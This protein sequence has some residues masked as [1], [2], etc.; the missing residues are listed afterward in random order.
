MAG[1]ILQSDTKVAWASRTDSPILTRAERIDTTPSAASSD[2]RPPRTIFPLAEHRFA[3]TSPSPFSTS[4]PMLGRNPNSLSPFPASEGTTPLTSDG[5]EDPVDADGMSNPGVSNN[6]D[7]FQ[8]PNRGI[9]SA[10]AE[11]HQLHRKITM[12]TPV[13]KFS[14][15]VI[16]DR[17]ELRNQQSSKMRTHST[18]VRKHAAQFQPTLSVQRAIEEQRGQESHEF[19]LDSTA[20]I[21]ALRHPPASASAGASGQFSSSVMGTIEEQRGQSDTPDSLPHTAKKAEPPEVNDEGQPERVSFPGQAEDAN[22]KRAEESPTWGEPFRLQWVKVER[23]PFY[24]TR[25]LRNPWN[26]DREIKVSRDGTELEPRVGQ[27]LLEEWDRVIETHSTEK[28]SQQ[29]GQGGAG[30]GGR[31][32]GKGKGGGA[33]GGVQRGKK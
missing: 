3:D 26:H 9:V 5:H 31:H 15:D 29:S 16:P 13:A 1:P 4:N 21:R 11:L 17:H 27:A 18:P 28:P 7:D 2:T 14:A 23:L 30:G 12:D 32:Q 8:E 24:R 20:P 6:W 22:D 25:H 19:H 33:G 10:P